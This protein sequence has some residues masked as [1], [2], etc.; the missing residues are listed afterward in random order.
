MNRHQVCDAIRQVSLQVKSVY[1]IGLCKVWCPIETA[2]GEF[3]WTFVLL[4]A[5][6]FSDDVFYLKGAECP[7]QKVGG[8]SAKQAPLLTYW[9]LQTAQG[10]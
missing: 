10:Y 1:Q 9:A 5:I 7:K 6:K 4:K 2:T 8:L 3:D